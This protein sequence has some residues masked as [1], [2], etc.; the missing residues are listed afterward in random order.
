MRRAL[1]FIVCG[2]VALIP[3]IAWAAEGAPSETTIP[4]STGAGGLTLGGG[5]AYWLLH[6]RVKAA[7]ALAGQI[8]ALTAQLS[9][10]AKTMTDAID[11]FKAYTQAARQDDIDRRAKHHKLA[12]T[13]TAHGYEFVRIR[14]RFNALRGVVVGIKG[15]DRGVPSEMTDEITAPKDVDTGR[16]RSIRGR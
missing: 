11:D 4:I 14:E 10:L 7:E 16:H 12:D 8:P 9:V 2:L 1:P 13:V 5:V 3:L 15:D 6:G